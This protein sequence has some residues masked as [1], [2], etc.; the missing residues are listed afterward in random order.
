MALKDWKNTTTTNS[1]IE[2]KKKGTNLELGV[3]YDDDIDTWEVLSN[4]NE[5]PSS[6]FFQPTEIP[7]CLKSFNTKLKALRFAKN[8]MRSH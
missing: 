2:W 5:E 7:L 3:R 6:T 4:A 8:Y 1:F